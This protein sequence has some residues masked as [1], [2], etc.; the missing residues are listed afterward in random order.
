MIAFD[1]ATS[2][3]L[4][5]TLP[6]G[7]IGCVGYMH[8]SLLTAIGAVAESWAIV[9]VDKVVKAIAVPITDKVFLEIKLIIIL[10]AV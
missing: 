4:L 8:G 2:S 1:A 9:V 3:S 10:L 6:S 5:A 7:M